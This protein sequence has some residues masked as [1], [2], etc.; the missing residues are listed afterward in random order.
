MIGSP[1]SFYQNNADV[2][3]LSQKSSKISPRAFVFS[4]VWVRPSKNRKYLA[5]RRETCRHHSEGLF[6][7]PY[8]FFAYIS[9]VLSFLTRKPMHYID[10]QP[11]SFRGIHGS[12][13]ERQSKLIS[14]SITLHVT[15]TWIW[16]LAGLLLWWGSK[17]PDY[18]LYVGVWLHYLASLPPLPRI[19]PAP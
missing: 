18:S 10:F 11:Q 6:N 5:R 12:E 14:M 9:A 7:W 8:I 17:L 16:K 13:L 1:F 3:F 15:C 2:T 4:E 19:I